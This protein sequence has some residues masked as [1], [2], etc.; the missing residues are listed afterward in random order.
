MCVPVCGAAELGHAA[1]L[2]GAGGGTAALAGRT[3]AAD[4]VRATGGGVGGTS[5]AVKTN[6]TKP[7]LAI[8]PK[9]LTLNI[10]AC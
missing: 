4:W 6:P 1:R 2:A 7:K 3:A 5:H 10:G 8:N 9:N